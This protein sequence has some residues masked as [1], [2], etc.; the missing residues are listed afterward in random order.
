MRRIFRYFIKSAVDISKKDSTNL[1][2]LCNHKLSP[3]LNAS[4]K[5]TWKFELFIN[6]KISSA[7]KN[8]NSFIVLFFY[9]F[10]F[11]KIK[12]NK[13]NST[14]YFIL[15]FKSIISPIWYLCFSFFSSLGI[16]RTFQMPCTLNLFRVS[17]R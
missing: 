8:Y 10:I 5:Y 16:A 14:W 3:I 9:I 13:L 6:N 7:S 4:L 12:L 17:P 15:Y 1:K 11:K 2:M